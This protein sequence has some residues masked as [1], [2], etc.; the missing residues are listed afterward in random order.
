VS[1]S[2]IN[3]REW[4]D[5]LSFLHPWYFSS[6]LYHLV[7]CSHIKSI[8]L[9]HDIYY[10]HKGLSNMCNIAHVKTINSSNFFVKNNNYL[11]KILYL[12]SNVQVLTQNFYFNLLNMCKFAHDRKSLSINYLV[13]VLIFHLPKRIQLS[14][15]IFFTYTH[16]QWCENSWLFFTTSRSWCNDPFSFVIVLELY[17]VLLS[18]ND[19]EFT[20]LHIWYMW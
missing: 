3:F 11:F 20:L 6:T 18:G 1:C 7:S 4:F 9:S 8:F 19:L 13:R 16:S 10:F 12:I 2:A 14:W 17:N 15:T 5:L